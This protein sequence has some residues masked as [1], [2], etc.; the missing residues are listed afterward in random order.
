MM[1]TSADKMNKTDGVKYDVSKKNLNLI[2]VVEVDLNKVSDEIKSELNLDEF[3]TTG[4]EFRK[5]AEAD[6]ATCK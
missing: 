4:T 1:K 5:S 2:V 3:N 6:G